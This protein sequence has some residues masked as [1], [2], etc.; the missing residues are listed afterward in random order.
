MSF[1]I[2]ISDRSSFIDKIELKNSIVG[3]RQDGIVHIMMKSNF[4]LR[5]AD[6]DE[7]NESVIKFG[8]GQK[9]ITML[10]AGEEITID[11]E[12]REY[13]ATQSQHVSACAIIVNSLIYKLVTNFYIYFQRPHYPIKIF[14]SEEN[15]L[16]WLKQ[17]KRDH[18]D[19]NSSN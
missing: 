7:I 15:A 4:D 18:A 19:Q 3:L 1:I 11:V 2:N 12:V 13:A 8:R 10:T 14:N 16:E 6:V 5:I 17:F 9:I